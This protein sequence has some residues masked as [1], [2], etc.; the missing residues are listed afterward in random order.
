MS[1]TVDLDAIR[2]RLDAADSA[3][4]DGWTAEFV[5]W[6]DAREGDYG[7]KDRKGNMVVFAPSEE[8]AEFVAHAHEDI[9]ALLAEVWQLHALKDDILIRHR[10]MGVMPPGGDLCAW[11]K[12]R[13]WPCP[14]ARAAGATS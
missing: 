3:V 9:S 1:G 10:P 6:T 8:V 7:V 14:D 4:Y 2:D 5:G 12:D 13:A 11:C